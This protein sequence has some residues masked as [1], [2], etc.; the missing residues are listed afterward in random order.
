MNWRQEDK[1]KTMIWIESKRIK[2]KTMIWIEGKRVQ[3]RQWFE[4]EIQECDLILWFEMKVKGNNWRL[5]FEL[6]LKEYNGRLWFE[7]KVKDTIKDYDLT[8][9]KERKAHWRHNQGE[10]YK[11]SPKNTEACSFFPKYHRIIHIKK[12]K[13]NEKD[14][15]PLKII[16][17]IISTKII[18]NISKYLQNLHIWICNFQLSTTTSTLVSSI[19]MNLKKMR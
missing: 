16:T 19:K 14:G 3:W 2:L 8:A 15:K 6:K 12:V 18:R 1:L 11:I 13:F 5:R 10:N 4:L 17:I 7:L 9:C